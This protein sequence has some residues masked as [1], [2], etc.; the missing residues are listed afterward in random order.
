MSLLQRGMLFIT[1][2]HILHIRVQYRAMSNYFILHYH[3]I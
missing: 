3:P 2:T 1:Y